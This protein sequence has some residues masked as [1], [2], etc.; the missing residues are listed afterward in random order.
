[1]DADDTAAEKTEDSV[2][3]APPLAAKT[4]DTIAVNS[5]GGEVHNG[6]QQE[7]ADGD[8]EEMDDG[9]AIG[10]SRVNETVDAGEGAPTPV[11]EPVNQTWAS[12][13]ATMPLHAMAG[14]EV[15]TS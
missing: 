9:G 4:D 11:M 3:T 12:R 15:S 7:V 8:E 10:D 5:V 6:G 1:M 14:Q 13:W 2:T